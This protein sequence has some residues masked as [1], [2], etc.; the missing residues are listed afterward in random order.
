MATSSWV[1]S[2]GVV[3][4]LGPLAPVALSPFFGVT[5]LSGLALWGPEWVTDNALLGASGPLQ[6]GLLFAVFLVLTI[7]T[8]LPRLTKVSKP[9]AQAVD[10]LETYAVIVIL[11]VIKVEASMETAGDEQVALVQLGIVSFTLDT[12]LAI[13]MVVNILVINSVK[14]FFEFMVW[15]T[16]VPL[17]GCCLRGLQQNPLRCTDGGLCIQSH[18]R[19]DDQSV[20]VA[21]RRNR[22]AVDQSPSPFLSQHDSGPGDRAIVERL[23]NTE[24]ARADSV[25]N[26][27]Y[28]AI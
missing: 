4:W 28:R 15:L 9:F 21:I 13:T 6:S 16:P 17:L 1:N 3:D 10:R 25:S 11:L 20:D 8:S 18:G 5:C 27:R 19:N 24:A 22:V 14:F 23:R 12:L 2:T 7:L 26:Q